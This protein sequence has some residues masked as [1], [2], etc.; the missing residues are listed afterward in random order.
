MTVQEPD[1]G[2]R[3]ERDGRARR[4]ATYV[5]LEHAA[6]L[7]GT[8]PVALHRLIRRGDLTAV[9]RDDHVYVSLASVLDY[10]DRRRAGRR[11]ALDEM[12]RVT[13]EGGLYDAELEALGGIVL[14]ERA[15]A[16]VHDSFYV[17][18]DHAAVLIGAAPAAVEELVRRGELGA[19][20]HGDHGYLSLQ[21]VLDYERRQRVERAAALDEMIRVSEEDGVYDSESELH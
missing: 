5:S 3:V 15:M 14:G 19:L 21:S 13:G 8:A 2:A 17:P 9:P 1:G 4:P 20:V 12:F 10:R 18:L 6:T 16:V 7:I 11:E